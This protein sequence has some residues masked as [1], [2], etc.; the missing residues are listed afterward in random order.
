[1]GFLESSVRIRSMMNH[2]RSK[3]FSYETVFAVIVG[4]AVEMARKLQDPLA[5]V[6][7]FMTDNDI[8][9]RSGKDGDSYS[10]R[11]LSQY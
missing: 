2:V 11:K 1:M 9:F 3:T 4:G 5:N 7:A 10:L 6:F 8:Q